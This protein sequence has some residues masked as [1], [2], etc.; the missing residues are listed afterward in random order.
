LKKLIFYIFIFL[1]SFLFSQRDT[2][3]FSSFHVV[4]DSVTIT[5]SKKDFDVN[6]FIEMVQNDNS[7][8]LAFRNIRTLS[9]QFD[10]D[11]KMFTKRKKEKATYKSKIRQYSDGKCRSGKIMDEEI[12]GNF[13]KRKKRYRYYTA[14]MFDR[15]FLT[16][17]KVCT[18]K[19]EEIEKGIIEDQQLKGMSKHINELKKLIFY[20][21]Q[22]ADVPFIGKKTAIFEKK[23]AKYYNFKI[24][25]KKYKSGID[26]YVFIAQAKPEVPSDKTVIKYMETFFDKSTFQ[27]VARNYY[28]KHS[29]FTFD[30][31]VKMKIKLTK[32]KEKYVPEFIEYNGNWD[33]PARR[34]EISKFSISF[35]DYR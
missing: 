3:E 14:K 2:I 5:A 33:V 12:T 10:S 16:H 7:F 19:T 22:K 32:I 4:L 26:C 18:K 24:K 1:P 17:G 13:Y 27:V 11:F 9:Y 21:G 23:M 25:S 15:L 8:Y 31:D 35:F 6:D 34:P 30:F 29:G 28:L 20:P